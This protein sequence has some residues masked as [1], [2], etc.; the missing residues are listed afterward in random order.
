[1]A[2]VIKQSPYDD[3]GFIISN[4]VTDMASNGSL[5]QSTYMNVGTAISG[6]TDSYYAVMLVR[7]TFTI[8]INAH[9]HI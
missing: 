7:A 4:L 2:W 3:D 1:M 6:K 9:V 5:S 8:L